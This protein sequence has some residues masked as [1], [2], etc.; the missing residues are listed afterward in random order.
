MQYPPSYTVPID[1]P[2]GGLQQVPP[3]A[4]GGLSMTAYAAVSLL[5]AGLGGAATGWLAEGSGRG[6]ITGAA[7]TSGLAGIADS[8]A[9]FRSSK[10]GLAFTF[11]VIG[12]GGLVFAINRAMQRRR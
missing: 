2:L 8:A 9:F 7:F 4:T 5:G 11:A 1:V 12:L 3:E 6:A 10:N